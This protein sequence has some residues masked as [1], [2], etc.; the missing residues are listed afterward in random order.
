MIA[1]VF[2][3]QA[4]GQFLASVVALIVTTAFKKETDTLLNLCEGD[5]CVQ[6]AS[7][8]LAVD[9]MWRIIIGFGAIPAAI[10]LYCRLTIPETPRYTFYVSRDVEQGFADYRAWVQN[11]IGP[12]HGHGRVAP[13]RENI[14]AR[15]NNLPNH[16]LSEQEVPRSSRRDFFNHFGQCKNFRVLVGIAGSWF[17]LDAAYYALALNNTIF[18]QKLGYGGF[19]DGKK[20]TIYALLRNGAVGNLILVCAGAMPGSL[21]TIYFVDRIGRKPIQI[22][23][24]AIVTVLLLILGSAFDDISD[25]SR[26]ALFVLCLLFFNFGESPTAV[27]PPVLGSN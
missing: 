15:L 8:H 11:S 1:S 26:V 12:R 19:E 17:F 7:G 4:L 24:F 27:P 6:T 5:T 25:G 22:G 16:G 13:D 2:A 18:L 20:Y 10:A 3:T 14:R 9:R 23:G 21:L